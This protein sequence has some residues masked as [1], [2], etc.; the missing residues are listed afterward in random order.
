MIAAASYNPLHYALLGPFYGCMKR[1]MLHV[2]LG[3]LH[4]TEEEL[5]TT[6]RRIL[7]EKGE[8]DNVTV[9]R[10]G[11]INPQGLISSLGMRNRIERQGIHRIFLPLLLRCAI[12]LLLILFSS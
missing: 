6:K 2:A 8:E 11:A 7:W 9:V 1:E 10:R 4:L 3:V 5:Y 12:C